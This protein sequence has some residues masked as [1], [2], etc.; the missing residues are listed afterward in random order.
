MKYFYYG[1]TKSTSF[2][3]WVINL[4]YKRTWFMTRI[5]ACDRPLNKGRV[6]YHQVGE[7]VCL[8]L[9]LMGKGTYWFLYDWPFLT[10]PVTKCLWPY[11][12][13]FCKCFEDLSKLKRIEFSENVHCKKNPIDFTVRYL[14]SGCQFTCHYFY[15]RIL[16]E[17]FLEIKKW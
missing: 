2:S 16:V 15:G 11:N 14:A 3:E 6:I 1:F 4:A 8:L 7:G 9:L 5:F 13:H 10:V 12:H 17:H